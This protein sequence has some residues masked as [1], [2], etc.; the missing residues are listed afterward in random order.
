VHEGKTLVAVKSR[1]EDATEVRRILAHAG[2]NSLRDNQTD[3]SGSDAPVD[4]ASNA[5]AVPSHELHE[6]STTV[7]SSSGMPP[8]ADPAAQGAAVV[9]LPGVY[10]VPAT[11]T[12]IGTRG[13]YDAPTLTDDLDEA[14][15][16]RSETVNMAAGTEDPYGAENASSGQEG[17]AI[18]AEGW[19]R[20]G[21]YGDRDD[22]KLDKTSEAEKT[23]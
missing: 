1:E 19:N 2:A 16:A 9:G 3:I 13:I 23:K 17:K 18:L 20:V 6:G 22:E 11:N 15:A 7:R 8:M 4:I 10:E 14:A 21:D 5:S 12:A